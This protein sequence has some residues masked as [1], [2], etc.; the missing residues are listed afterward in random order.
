MKILTIFTATYNRGYILPVLYKSLCDQ[1]NKD[2]EW[3]IVDDGSSDNTSE[4]INEW[5][6]SNE[7][8]IRYI[9]QSNGGKMKAH[10]TGVLNTITDLFV[11]VD[12]D[13][14]LVHDAV[15]S[16]IYFWKKVANYK[17]SGIVS[18]KGKNINEVVGSKFPINICYSKLYK[19]YENGFKGD[20]TLVFRT[21]ILKEFLF[22]EIKGEKFI[23]E[24]YVYNQIDQYY[25]MAVFSK[26]IIICKY[27]DDGYTNNTIKLLKFNPK[28]WSLYLNQKAKYTKRLKN[29]L[30]YIL[31]Y[32]SFSK[33]AKNKHIITNSSNK[34]LTIIFYPLG[35][36]L[37]F[38][39]K[40]QFN[41]I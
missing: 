37:Y 10:N 27:L 6:N 18:Y 25:E 32:I 34:I 39:R 11:C 4:I 38:R 29:K 19:L 36:I 28:G 41:N 22:P 35:I 31:Q 33:Y 20:T 1:T 8:N 7:I 23:P 21:Q 16:I 40:K 14:F 13:D 17:L 9:Y 30:Y 3:L 2:F 5:I 26:I 12:S 24:D 15:E